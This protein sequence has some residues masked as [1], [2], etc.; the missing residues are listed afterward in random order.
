MP[1][2]RHDDVKK[3]IAAIAAKYGLDVVGYLKLDEESAI[4]SGKMCL[5]KG[6]DTE[7]DVS[8]IK[9]PMELMPGARAMIIFGKRLM[10]DKYGLDIYY[11]IS[12]DYAASIE[13]MALD[14]AALKTIERL[15]KGG[16]LGEEYAPYDMKAWAALAGLGWIGKSGMFVSKEH[17]P[18]LRLKGI[19]TDADIGEPGE[20]PGDGCKEC[21]ECVKACPVGAISKKGVDSKKCGACPLNHRKI[22]AYSYSNCMACTSACP[23]GTRH[24]DRRIRP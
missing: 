1:D 14:I 7:V 23:V 8:N 6:A 4:L 24:K 10:D 17:G 21:E 5:L 16:Y 22:L 9:N 20:T 11:R 12:E 19:L 15:K 18:R 3:D 13:M 2:A